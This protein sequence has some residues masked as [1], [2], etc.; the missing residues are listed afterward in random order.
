MT[1]PL[2]AQQMQLEGVYQGKDLYV[3]NPMAGDF[4]G[5]C[6]QE[7]YVNEQKMAEKLQTSAF[8]VRLSH[9]Q[10][11]E[12][13]SIRFVHKPGCQPRVLN[14]QVIRGESEKFQFRAIKVSSDSV[15]WL[16][17]GK[18]KQGLFV[19]ERLQANKWQSVKSLEVQ[20]DSS[21]QTYQLA[22]NHNPGNN[23][24]RIRLVEEKGQIFYS[25]QHDFRLED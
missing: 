14:P 7:V 9:L 20:A 21:V 6:V 4:K 8:V 24:Y 11:G 2:N 15:R 17:A 10:V 22:V 12:H 25:Q 23:T 16:V 19:V 3:Q 13:V 1:F 18:H 5:F